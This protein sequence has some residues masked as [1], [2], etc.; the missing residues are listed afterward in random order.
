MRSFGT[1]IPDITFEPL[2]EDTIEIVREDLE[3]VVNYD[4]RVSLVDMTTTPVPANHVLN[5]VLKL[6][7]IEFNVTLNTSLNIQFSQNS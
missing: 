1:R 3:Y 7:Y 5:V 6:F 4:P 2:T